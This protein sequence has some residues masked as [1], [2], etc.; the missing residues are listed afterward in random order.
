VDEDVGDQPL[1][2]LDRQSSHGTADIPPLRS[3]EHGTAREAS[4]GGD[5]G[6]GQGMVSRGGGGVRW[7]WQKGQMLRGDR[8]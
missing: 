6:Q 3:S 5:G 8:G 7:T 2:Y 1:C 4:R